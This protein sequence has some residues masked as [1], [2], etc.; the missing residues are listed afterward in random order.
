VLT[1]EGRMTAAGLAAFAHR[2]EA[3][4]RTASY[5]QATMPLLDPA[6]QAEF[7]RNPA[8][9]KFFQAQ[10][11]SYRK[12]AIWIVVSA[13]QASTRQRRLDALIAASAKG[14]RV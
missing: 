6:V 10:A 14:L 11:P 3:R 1:R 13:K 2:T 7:E 9:W 5:E 8:A 4:S 12:K